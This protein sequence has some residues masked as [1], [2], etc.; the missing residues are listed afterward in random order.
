M[1]I[2]RWTWV[3]AIGSPR[4]RWP[5]SSINLS[6]LISHHSSVK[7]FDP[8]PAIAP[9]VQLSVS[10]SPVLSLTDSALGLTTWLMYG[11]QPSE[12]VND[13]SWL[14]SSETSLTADKALAVECKR[15]AI[16][17]D[18]RPNLWYVSV[19]TLL[20]SPILGLYVDHFGHL[21]LMYDQLMPVRAIHAIH[22]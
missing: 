9:S 11:K 16:H 14:K 8:I 2:T 7:V 6:K 5:R 12:S 21:L 1:C 3:S 18:V 4:S 20:H 17:C 13:W 19:V 10:L 15:S 22:V